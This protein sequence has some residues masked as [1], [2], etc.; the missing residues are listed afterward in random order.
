MSVIICSAKPFRHLLAAKTDSIGG[1]VPMI[2][3]M[4]GLYRDWATVGVPYC[5]PALSVSI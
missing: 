1:D 2:G 3:L 5:F 4:I